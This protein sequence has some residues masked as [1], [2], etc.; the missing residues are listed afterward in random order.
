MNPIFTKQEMGSEISSNILRDTQPK[1]PTQVSV[2]PNPSL[3]II[4]NCI[5]SR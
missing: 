2:A 3:I 5:S 1:I 4:L